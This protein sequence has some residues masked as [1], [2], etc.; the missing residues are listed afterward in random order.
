M[1]LVNNFIFLGIPAAV[2]AFIAFC[3][4]VAWAAE[5]LPCDSNKNDVSFGFATTDKSFSTESKARPKAKRKKK[6]KDEPF[7]FAPR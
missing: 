5:D 4:F 2:I 6:A 3:W 1:W 7:G